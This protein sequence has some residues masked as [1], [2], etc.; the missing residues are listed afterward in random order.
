MQ[1]REKITN[2]CESDAYGYS[3]TETYLQHLQEGIEDDQSLSLE[4]AS[5]SVSP[6]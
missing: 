6:E 3:S 1:L 5:S 4:L 2:K